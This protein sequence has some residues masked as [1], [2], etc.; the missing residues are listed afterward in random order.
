MLR[1]DL[2]LFLYKFFWTGGIV[3]KSFWISDQSIHAN[4]L[5]H[6]QVEVI[7][8]E[9]CNQPD[10]LGNFV[11]DRMMCAGSIEGG[12]NTCVVKSSIYSWLL[13]SLLIRQLVQR[14]RI[15][16]WSRRSE[17]QISGRQSS[18]QCCQRLATAAVFL[19]QELYFP[20]TMMRRWAPQTRY[21]RRCITASVLIDWLGHILL[22]LFSD[23]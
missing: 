7:G 5:W 2:I 15:R 17:V 18:T 4:T 21:T 3:R 1:R 6:S 23:K 8:N 19:Q 9:R 20:R 22:Y 11:S 14:W 13:R 10:W 16:L 12:I